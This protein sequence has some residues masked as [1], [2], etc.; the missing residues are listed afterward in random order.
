MFV[1]SSLLSQRDIAKHIGKAFSTVSGYVE[2]FPQF[3]P[4]NG[5]PGLTRRYYPQAL[6]VAELISEL[7][8]QR[9]PTEEILRALGERFPAAPEAK[10]T[11][12]RQS[13]GLGLPS[14][15][16]A[17][18][19]DQDSMNVQNVISNVQADVQNRIE[20]SMTAARLAAEDLTRPLQEQIL[21][22]TERVFQL[23]SVVAQL[24]QRLSQAD[25]EREEFVQALGAD[26]LERDR[27]M[28]EWVRGISQTPLKREPV[29]Q[30]LWR[31]IAKH[32]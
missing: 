5:K 6:A 3:F 32:D 16:P 15:S 14:V 29:M 28:V 31:R 7:K 24:E 25:R 19:G 12:T 17:G 11:I 9:V 27:L 23:E 1:Q 18:A 20:R 2:Q 4:H 26:L 22:L 30:S 13:A 8:T 10:P 21:G